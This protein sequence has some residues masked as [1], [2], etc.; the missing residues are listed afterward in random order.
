MAEYRA[1]IVLTLAVLAIALAPVARVKPVRK[2]RV[3][4]APHIAVANDL[5]G[6]WRGDWIGF[7]WEPQEIR[8]SSNGR[9]LTFLDSEKQTLT[10][11]ELGRPLWTVKWPQDSPPAQVVITDD[12]KRVALLDYQTTGFHGGEGGNG[13]HFVLLGEHG[14][15][16]AAYGAEEILMKGLVSPTYDRG[17]GQKMLGVEDET[18]RIDSSQERL[19][20][21]RHGVDK[22]WFWPEPLRLVPIAIRLSDGAQLA[23]SEEE[24]REIAAPYLTKMRAQLSSGEADKRYRAA[25]ALGELADHES[26]L[27]L[28]RIIEADD[29]TNDETRSLHDACRR[30]L[31]Q[32]LGERAEPILEKHPELARFAM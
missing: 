21:L 28:T 14:E 3:L 8:A 2:E 10:L 29:D 24:S 16:L 18:V 15:I 1:P 22:D 4:V 27:A 23:L 7:G 5:Y 17:P 9:F 25:V 31:S 11:K 30:S 13:R 19:V 26:V 32:I 20:F 12:G 6:P